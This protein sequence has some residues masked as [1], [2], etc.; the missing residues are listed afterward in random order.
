MDANKLGAMFLKTEILKISKGISNLIYFFST[1]PLGICIW[2]TIYCRLNQFSASFLDWASALAVASSI[3]IFGLLI[4]RSHW[5]KVK[6]S[7]FEYKRGIFVKVQDVSWSEVEK[8]ATG[9]FVEATEGP[10]QMRIYHSS[11]ILRIAIKWF[12]KQDLKYFVS[13][14]VKNSPNAKFDKNT[15]NFTEK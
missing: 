9:Y 13:T 8:V 1:I 2:G 3:A 12:S 15:K 11:K 5:L 10:L 7:G 14:L 4:T 6:P